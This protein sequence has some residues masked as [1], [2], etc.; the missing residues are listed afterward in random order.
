MNL[1]VI[2]FQTLYHYLSNS[3]FWR[4]FVSIFCA[5]SSIHAQK[6][7]FIWF[8]LV[9]LFPGLKLMLGLMDFQL[10]SLL[11][12]THFLNMIH[13]L[14]THLFKLDYP[15]LVSTASDHCLWILHC[16]WT[17]SLPNPCT[18]CTTE[19]DALRGYWRNRSFVII[20]IIIITLYCIS[21]T[22]TITEHLIN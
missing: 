7:L 14:K 17:M 6:T 4:T 20:V 19:L 12:E 1:I 3:F 9:R 10:P 16:T 11:S 8:S 18:R 21:N 22:T 15:S 2:F 13:H 5:F